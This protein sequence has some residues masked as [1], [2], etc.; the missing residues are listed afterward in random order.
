[1]KNPSRNNQ[2][3][4]GHYTSLRITRPLENQVDHPTG[5]HAMIETYILK[6]IH[7]E[8]E[9]LPGPCKELFKLIFFHDM[10]TAE[11]AVT[12]NIPYKTA[13]K[14]QQQ[15]LSVLRFTVLKQC[16]VYQPETAS[17]H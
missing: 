11:A 3:P 16:L 6:E 1:M 13:L 12:L 17:A 15:A 9:S 2:R 14:H 5:E 10:N 7:E 4:A 8:I